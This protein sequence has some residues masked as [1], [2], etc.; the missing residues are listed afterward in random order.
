MPRPV[1]RLLDTRRV[2]RIRE[3]FSWID[4]RFLRDGWI[5]KLER[6]EILLY[7]F[8]IAVAD[9]DGLSYYSD[10]RVRGTVGIAQP[11]L[12]QARSRLL[13][14]ELIAF[15]PP[16]YQVL[17]LHVPPPRNS[18]MVSIKDVFRLIVE[19]HDPGP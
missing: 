4:R 1:K 2:R 14:L 18:E 17:A 12:D 7:F 9:K 5:D 19:R 6:D 16:L 15:D 11:A 3:G 13:D 8:L 10:P